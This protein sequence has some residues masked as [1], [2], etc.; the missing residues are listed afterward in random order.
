[1]A[2]DQ[3]DVRSIALFRVVIATAIL[4][5]ILYEFMPEAWWWFSDQ[6]SAPLLNLHLSNSHHPGGFS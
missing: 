3:V 1:M 4:W 2:H 5:D 6:G